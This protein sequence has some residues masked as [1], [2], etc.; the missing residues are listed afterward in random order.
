ME[1]RNQHVAY[2]S[3]TNTT[4]RLVREIAEEIGLPVAKEYNI[5]KD[6]RLGRVTLSDADLFVLGVPSYAGR[7][8]VPTVEMIERFRG[9][10]TPVV[11]MCTYGNRDYDDT[12]LELKDMVTKNGFKV[13]A[14]GAFVAQHSIF[15]KVGADR[16]DVKDEEERRLFARQ[17]VD[18]L[19]TLDVHTI[20][21]VKVKG[22]FPYRPTGSIPLKPSADKRCDECEICVRLCP[23][24]AIS[25]DN[26]RKT[27]GDKCISCARCIAVCPQ[28]ARAFRGLMYTIASRRFVK[29]HASVHQP[30]VTS[31]AE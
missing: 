31:F 6:N 12:L 20:S 10:N 26:P 7:V 15:P 24:D 11:I 9:N 28:H 8:P 27:D 29:K 1:F 2:F 4:K 30:N 18:R 13:I 22:N 19:E 14:A 3:T 23:T 21:E 5:T 25:A 16:P 17:I